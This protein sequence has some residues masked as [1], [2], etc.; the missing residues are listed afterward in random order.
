MVPDQRIPG[1][2]EPVLGECEAETPLFLVT[3]TLWLWRRNWRQSATSGVTR[4]AITAAQ[5]ATGACLDPNPIPGSTVVAPR[6]A[7]CPAER[8][9][10]QSWHLQLKHRFCDILN[11]PSEQVSVLHNGPPNRTNARATSKY[12]VTSLPEHR[13]CPIFARRNACIRGPLMLTVAARHTLA[14]RAG[15]TGTG[16]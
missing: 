9:I 11:T 5:A 7:S 14:D 13:S 2:V 10:Q 4:A 12:P 15:L 8:I 1:G 3:S 6:P 16:D